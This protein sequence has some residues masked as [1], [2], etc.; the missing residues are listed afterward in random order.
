MNKSRRKYLRK[1]L[2]IA[3]VGALVVLGV[4]L[5]RADGRAKPPPLTGQVAV[6]VTVA[7]AQRHDVPIFL[8]GLGTV[9]ASNTLAI[10]S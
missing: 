10:H 5:W 1:F 8:S 7:R 9:Q 3:A 6:P 2:G 4:V